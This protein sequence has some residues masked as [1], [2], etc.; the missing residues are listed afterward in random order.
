MTDSHTIYSLHQ[1]L[2]N[3]S[4]SPDPEF[5]ENFRCLAAIVWFLEDWL[6]EE[7]TN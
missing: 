2:L 3:T 4:E 7:M 1:M 6:M 5:V